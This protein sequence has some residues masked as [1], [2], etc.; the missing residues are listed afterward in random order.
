MKCTECGNSNL[1]ATLKDT[2]IRV[3]GH[4]V[5]GRVKALVCS[6]CGEAFFDG[7]DLERLDLEV[8][9]ELVRTGNVSGDAFR[10]VRKAI[11]MGAAELADLLGVAAETVSRWEKGHRDV[12]RLGWIV[13][14]ALL[15]DRREGTEET[16][17]AL[18]AI[19]HPTP[20]PA[21]VKV[22]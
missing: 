18:E 19:Q 12:D 3:G 1:E 4:M 20:M 16:R 5:S 15:R 10:F 2:E 8:A 17:R 11:G 13:L 9:N 14:A 21:T 6:S 7:P 22:A